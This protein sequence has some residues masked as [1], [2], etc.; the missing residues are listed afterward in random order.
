MKYFLVVALAAL[1]FRSASAQ[2]L[3]AKVAARSC[4]CLKKE[5]LVTEP[6]LRECISQSLT[7]V[8]VGDSTR[9]YLK[10]LSTVESIQNTTK[11]VYALLRRQC[12]AVT[13]KPR[14][15]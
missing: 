13:A 11:K 7:Q 14:E 4:D 6:M 3:E 5:K 10:Q 15:D 1:G 9:Q 12:E 2:S 8:L